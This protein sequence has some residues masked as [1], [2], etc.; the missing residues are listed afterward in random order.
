MEAFS[1]HSDDAL[2]A[3]AVKACKEANPDIEVFEG[4]IASGD[5]FVADQGVKDFIQKNLE[6]TLLKWK[7]R[8]SHRQHI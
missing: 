7:A 2:R 4:R 3:L 6:H 1:F 5:Q 8:Q